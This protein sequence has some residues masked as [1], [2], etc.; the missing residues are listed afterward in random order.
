MLMVEEDYKYKDFSVEF[1]VRDKVVV[2]KLW[3]CRYLAYDRIKKNVPF[4]TGYANSYDYLLADT[5]VG[6]AK[7]AP[8]DEFNAKFGKELALRRAR[9]KRNKAVKQAVNLYLKRMK[10][11]LQELENDEDIRHST[12]SVDDLI[13]R[14]GK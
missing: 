1:I 5:Y 4:V 11:M 3:N 7:C 8:E 2:C 13:K 12:P 6:I 14:A 10:Y 9:I